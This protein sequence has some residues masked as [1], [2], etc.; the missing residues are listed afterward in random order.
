LAKKAVRKIFAKLTTTVPI[1]VIPRPDFLTPPAIQM[2]EEEFEQRG[3]P[4]G[5]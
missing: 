3:E 5:N 2:E 1:Q 4:R